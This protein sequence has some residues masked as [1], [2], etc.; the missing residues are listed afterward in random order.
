[1]TLDEVSSGKVRIIAPGTVAS[2]DRFAIGE[3]IVAGNAMTRRAM[4]AF[5]N[6][7]DLEPKQ[8]ITCVS[9]SVAARASHVLHL[10]DRPDHANRHGETHRRA[11]HRNSYTRLTPRR[12]RRCTSGSR[13]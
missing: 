10:T 7:L 4:Y 3:N 11:W 13:S 1:V 12:R 8:F 6:L 5:G 2:F 9:R